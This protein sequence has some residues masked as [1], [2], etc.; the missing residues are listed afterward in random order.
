MAG[1]RV[2]AAGGACKGAGCCRGTLGRACWGV[3]ELVL[4]CVCRQCTTC[5]PPVMTSEEGSLRWSA[6]HG[7]F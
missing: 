7:R 3:C 2:G 6:K 4:V 5:Q 1:A